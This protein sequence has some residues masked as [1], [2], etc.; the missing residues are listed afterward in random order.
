MLTYHPWPVEGFPSRLSSAGYVSYLLPQP[1]NDTA[2]RRGR[3]RASPVRPWRVHALGGTAQHTAPTI[4]TN[5]ST[6]PRTTPRGSQN[7]PLHNHA[8]HDAWRS[9]HTN[10]IN[11]PRTTHAR[12][13]HAAVA[14]AAHTTTP[15][16]TARP[17]ITRTTITK[18]M[19]R[20][21]PRTRP[22]IQCAAGRALANGHTF[23]DTI[24]PAI[25][26]QRSLYPQ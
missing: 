5:N 8:A 7:I 14:T 2:P 21:I 17:R 6:T 19:T 4:P 16:G 11:I 22:Y 1:Q 18:P 3:Q 10:N 23:D 26:I 20:E 9:R 24:S 12:R 25:T 15:N 13:P